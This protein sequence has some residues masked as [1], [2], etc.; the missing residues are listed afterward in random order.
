M[1]AGRRSLARICQLFA[2]PLTLEEI[3]TFFEFLTIC[4]LG[5]LAKATSISALT[6]HLCVLLDALL[7]SPAPEGDGGKVSLVAAHGDHGRLHG[8][9]EQGTLLLNEHGINS[10]KRD[11]LPGAMREK[12]KEERKNRNRGTH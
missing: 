10:H 6:V 12:L 9:T 3:K 2:N 8:G 5:Y 1:A 7:E 4:L 11:P